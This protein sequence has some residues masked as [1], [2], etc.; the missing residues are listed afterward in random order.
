LV[1]TKPGASVIPGGLRPRLPSESAR[2]RAE[3]ALQ[4]IAPKENISWVPPVLETQ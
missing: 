2:Q 3:D 1:N 4:A